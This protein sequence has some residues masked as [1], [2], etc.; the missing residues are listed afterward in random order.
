MEKLERYRVDRSPQAAEQLVQRHYPL[1]VSICRRYLRRQQDVDDAVQET[2]LKL[3]HHAGVIHSDVQ[4]WL[5][6]AAYS[7]C[8]DFIRRVAA[9]RRRIQEVRLA[10]AGP[11]TG[12]HCV[13]HAAIA[14]KLHQAM[15]QLDE[16]ARNLLIDRFVRRTPL[17]VIAEQRQ[18]SI[19]TI[20]R[21]TQHAVS[22]LAAV[23]RDMGV[24]AADDLTV[25]EHFGDPANLPVSEWSDEQGLRFAPDWRAGQWPQGTAGLRAASLPGWTRPL[26]I[27]AFVSHL[28]LVA[29]DRAGR[30]HPLHA[31]G[32]RVR[33]P[34]V[35]IGT[36]SRMANPGYEFVGVTEP[37]SSHYGPIE[38]VLRDYE[39]LAG[40]VDVTDVEGLRTLDV[41]LLGNNWAMAPAVARA[42]HEA[43]RSGV[44]L[45]NDCCWIDL[46]QCCGRD[47]ADVRALALAESAIYRFH[48]TPQH[49]TPMRAIV[50]E[51]HSV[52]PGL[53]PH[54]E[55]VVPSCGPVYQVMRDATLLISRDHVVM[56]EEHRLPGIGPLRPPL[57]IVGQ[58]G[59][60]RVAVV[61]VHAHR[62][63]MMIP[64]LSDGYMDNLL[65]WLAEPRREA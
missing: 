49:E 63:I 9:Q 43:V 41:I 38:G 3:L 65:A 47:N 7:T 12:E 13:L 35:Q 56:P 58:L 5:T 55:A 60:G 18:V 37:G 16:A 4:G 51:A 54:T 29:P 14:E 39:V 33:E 53:G 59:A 6:T 44:G 11:S 40:L 2:F 30:S 62:R 31:D 24:E 52:L 25:A 50:H 8:V 64:G 19:A 42:L 27:G 57:Y 17:R 20:S 48:T 34:W 32:W 10:A 36:L 15:L 23:L 22:D 21:K 45:L 61:N 46:F 26:R 1:V 28:C